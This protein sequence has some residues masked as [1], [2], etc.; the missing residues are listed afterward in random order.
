MSGVLTERHAAI[1]DV[2]H[3]GFRLAAIAFGNRPGTDRLLRA[4]L[5]RLTSVPFAA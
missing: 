1:L 3:Y 4:A 5:P 2:L